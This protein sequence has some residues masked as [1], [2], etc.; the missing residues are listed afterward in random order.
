MLHLFIIY[1]S[2]K[3]LPILFQLQS[4]AV[5]KLFLIGTLTLEMIK[6]NLAHTH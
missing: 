1:K 4:G 5:K 3:I 6:D 2:K